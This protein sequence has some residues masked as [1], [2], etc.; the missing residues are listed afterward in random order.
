MSALA[1]ALS[2]SLSWA[3]SFV[4]TKHHYLLAT[5]CILSLHDPT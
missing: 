3:I 4:Q 5:C 1:V 2:E